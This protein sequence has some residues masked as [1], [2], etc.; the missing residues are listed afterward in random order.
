LGVE[1]LRLLLRR[2]RRIALDTSVFIYQM[3]ANERYLALTDAVFAWVER[4]GHEAVTSTITMTELL[5][6]SYRDNDEH[7]VDAFYG[8]LSTYP[9]LRWIA[10]DLEAADLAAKLRAQYRMRTPD[11][12]QAATAIRENATGLITNDPGFVRIGGFETAVLDRFV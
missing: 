9:N 1:Q 12:L 5:V 7:R 4:A 3:E 6:P 10:P 8:L 2:H 11:A